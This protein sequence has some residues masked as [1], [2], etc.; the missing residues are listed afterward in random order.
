MTQ[1]KQTN[2]NINIKSALNILESLGMAQKQI[3]DRSALTLL[4]LGDLG[5]KDHWKDFKT[6]MIGIHAIIGWIKEKYQITYAE[7][8]RESFR[9]KTLHQF[10]QGGLVELNPDNPSRKVNSS[11]NCYQINKL[12]SDLLI[13]FNTTQ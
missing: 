3:N 5:P 6:R 10:I 13:S 4:A 11:K 8:S 12:T 9:R 1:K 7:N 2:Q